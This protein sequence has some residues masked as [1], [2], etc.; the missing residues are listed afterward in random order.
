M[1]FDYSELKSLSAEEFKSKSFDIKTLDKNPAF[2]KAS[3]QDIAKIEKML[4]VRPGVLANEA[5]YVSKAKCKNCGKEM[6]FDD[7]VHTALT[8]AGHTKSD[9]LHT[10]VGSKMVVN[11]P[12]R[13]TCSAC[14]TIQDLD[15]NYASMLYGCNG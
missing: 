12:R 6:G 8:K 5:L 9:V 10:L 3:G 1:S 2:T 7:F 14:Q 15:S 11:S 4:D 13:L